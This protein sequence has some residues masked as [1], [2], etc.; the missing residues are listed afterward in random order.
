MARLPVIVYGVI[1]LLVFEEKFF[2]FTKV[3]KK[4]T[5]SYQLLQK[6]YVDLYV[7]AICGQ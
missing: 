7:V 1:A 5:H 2:H 6:V 4:E 3:K